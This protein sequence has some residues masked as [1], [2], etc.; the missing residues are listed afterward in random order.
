[1]GFINNRGVTNSL[2]AELGAAQAA[3]GNGQTGTAINLLGA[4]INNSCR[5]RSASQNLPVKSR[6][7]H[8]THRERILPLRAMRIC[9]CSIQN[10]VA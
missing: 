4:F 5:S 1:M 7:P 9:G 6:L 8:K 3:Q 2:L 10:Y